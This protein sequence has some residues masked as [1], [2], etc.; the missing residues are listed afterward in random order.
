[1]KQT[2]NDAAR[3]GRVT[4]DS[5]TK[6]GKKATGAAKG[7]AKGKASTKKGT[8]KGTAKGKDDRLSR[9]WHRFVAELRRL[10]DALVD[11]G[12]GNWLVWVLNK[13]GLFK[14]FRLVTKPTGS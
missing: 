9:E 8:T 5:A 14:N 1:M 10:W 13:T 11:M 3:K 2:V 4:K 6:T 7:A 12:L